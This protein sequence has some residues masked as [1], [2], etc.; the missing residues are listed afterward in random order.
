MPKYTTSHRLASQLHPTQTHKWDPEA[1]STCR[2]ADTHHESEHTQRNRRTHPG[3]QTTWAPRPV[4]GGTSAR[5]C[6]HTQHSDTYTDA[7]TYVMHMEKPYPSQSPPRPPHRP[8]PQANPSPAPLFLRRPGSGQA[9]VRRGAAPRSEEARP[10]CRGPG[11][12]GGSR[13]HSFGN[14][15]ATGPQLQRGRRRRLLQL[16]GKASSAARLQPGPGPH[17]APPPPFSETGCGTE[18]L[19]PGAEVSPC[20]GS[21]M[22]PTALLAVRSPRSFP[23]PQPGPRR[24][25]PSPALTTWRAISVAAIAPASARA[26]TGAA[27][28]GATAQETAELLRQRESVTLRA[29]PSPVGGGAREGPPRRCSNPN[30]PLSSTPSEVGYE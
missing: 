12:L 5:A 24:W 14:A 17:P 13:G 10:G 23:C 1:H 22:L 26:A 2:H 29:R 21:W 4:R 25:H 18:P 3:S 27:A 16:L 9:A 30:L 6:T 20:L 8:L 7:V 19:I 15:P 28:T 11:G